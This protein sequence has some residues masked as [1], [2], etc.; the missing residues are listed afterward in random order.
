MNRR[1]NG[2]HLYATNETESGT[3]ELRRLIYE[4]THI[5]ENKWTYF[6]A[7]IRVHC[8]ERKRKLVLHCRKRIAPSISC[9]KF[10]A[11]RCLIK[12]RIRRLADVKQKSFAKMSQVAFKRSLYEYSEWQIHNF[13]WN[14]KVAQNK[15]APEGL[16]VNRFCVL[17]ETAQL[18]RN[19]LFD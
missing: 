7:R 11:Y 6:L 19:Y 2:R 1:M 13:L 10:T 3:I 17:L 16:Q 8:E 12:R 5:T 18:I 9:E 15:N 14:S 4:R